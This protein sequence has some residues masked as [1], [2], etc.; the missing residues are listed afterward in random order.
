ML[1]AGLIVGFA[2][3]A[4]LANM[5]P[6]AP[7]SMRIERTCA[8]LRNDAHVCWPGLSA[9]NAA[10]DSAWHRTQ[11]VAVAL[12]ATSAAPTAFADTGMRSVSVSVAYG[13]LDMSREAG[14][15]T[16]LRRIESAARTACGDASSHLL[17][18]QTRATCRREAVSRAVLG[19][20]V[21]TL[22]FAW[23][24]SEGSSTPGH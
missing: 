16:L 8:S 12:A 14:G 1:R 6:S 18:Y 21:A 9:S 10:A 7:R 17:V 24:G 22:T 11:Y 19:L 20:D 2:G 4:R 13:D 3:P 5:G 15:A 23:N